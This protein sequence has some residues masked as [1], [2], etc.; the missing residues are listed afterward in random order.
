L[1]TEE[2][3]SFATLLRRY[4]EAAGLSQEELA[5]RAGLTA[6]AVGALERGERRRPFPETVRRLANA[7]GLSEQERAAFIGAVRRHA[8]AVP[9]PQ[10]TPIAPPGPA[11]P[12]LPMPLTPLIGREQ[13]VAAVIALLR[14]DAVRL[15]TLS[16]PGGVGKTRLALEVARSLGDS[17]RGDVVLVALAALA[18]P[19]LVMTAIAQALGLREAGGQDPHE[20]LRVN[21]RSRRLLLV[22]DNFEHVVAAAPQVAALLADCPLVVALVTSRVTLRVRGEREYGVAPLTLPDLT[23][24]P[25]LEEAAAAAAVQL[26]AE[27]AHEADTHFALTQA[28]AAPVAAIC[29]RLDGLPLAL[30]LAAARMKLLGP[31]ALLARLDRALPLLVG[32]ARDLPARQ[33]TMRQAVAWSDALLESQERLVFRRLCI[34]VGGCDLE[35]AEAVCAEADTESIDVLAGVSAL[36]EAS[37]LTG[38]GAAGVQVT[39]S[40]STDTQPRL[41]MLETIREYGLE[42]LAASGELPA[43][44]R[45][46]ARYYLALAETG[47]AALLGPEQGVWVTH[48]EQEHD[49]LRAALRWALDGTAAPVGSGTA[50]GSLRS[51][52]H[53]TDL[54][55]RGEGGIEDADAVARQPD[56]EAMDRERTVLG[57]RLGAALWR[58]W[59]MHGH[60][61]E[62][63]DWL[64]RLVVLPV[65]EDTA[66]QAA[67]AGA[68]TAAGLLALVQGDRERATVLC[69]E[70]LAL[71][72]QRGDIRGMAQALFGLRRLEESAALYRQLGD[73]QGLAESL[74]ELALIAFQHGDDARAAQLYDE[75]L[76]LARGRGDRR[77][78]AL[79]LGGLGLIETF[80][81][82]N[83]VR[84][85]ALQEEALS[86]HRE[87]GDTRGIAISLTDLGAA[88]AMQGDYARATAL[89]EAGI[90][91]RR[92]V[93]DQFGLADSLYTLAEVKRAQGDLSQATALFEQSLRRF[94]E[95]GNA[96]WL[97]EPLT[98]FADVARRQGNYEQAGELLEE[99]LALSDGAG[100]RHG[101]AH[102]LDG[103]G[104]LAAAQGEI[105]H[106]RTLHEQ[107]LTLYRDL[108]NRAGIAAALSHLADVTRRE[109]DPIRAAAL[110]SESLALY[111]ALGNGRGSATALCGLGEAA[112]EAGSLDEARAYHEEGLML[113]RHMGTREE[114]ARAL[115]GLSAVAH[116]MGHAEAA[117]R[118]AG[119]ADALREQIGAIVPPVERAA[120]ERD[121][122]AFREALGN[123][124]FAAVW[125]AGQRLTPDQEIAA[126]FGEPTPESGANVGPTSAPQ[127]SAGRTPH[128][129]ASAPAGSR[130]RRARM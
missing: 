116:A 76:A 124:A 106:A 109:G 125:V 7:F 52:R 28:N 77:G 29:R 54:E 51:G 19:A 55:R 48:L 95:L 92:E 14:G 99:L 32:G 2:R 75:C 98:G 66:A 63:R 104:L 62:G 100:D 103:Q 20:L 4:R 56:R 9:D 120:R 8:E 35:A 130:R 85:A 27:R 122:A 67:R 30:E 114:I 65:S 73:A 123:D 88:V 33:R 72:Q 117:A 113:S 89:I 118:L 119:A 41:G 12:V 112:R 64:D 17:D 24:L 18:E 6:K 21:L 108:D 1:S 90:P 121:L 57:L 59:H 39:A 46:H 87:L 126:A 129:T 23:R 26:F 107:A 53:V 22:L 86:L 58:F 68:L 49:N 127:T 50:M 40:D 83:F 96:G 82:G 36:L 38:P 31:T 13:D 5:E 70:G 44:A 60:A 25:T 80:R 93:G 111:R 79:A 11:V 10:C 42:Q 128:A 94:R 45:R 71:H 74:L 47:A 110:G 91:L 101:R 97:A 16:G 37:L 78:I 102:A 61:R 81:R 34:F 84:A 115:A 69:T 3:V 43:L 105:A 15:L